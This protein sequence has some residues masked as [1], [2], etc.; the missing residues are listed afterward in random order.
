MARHIQGSQSTLINS[1]S[2]IRMYRTLSFL[3]QLLPSS[4]ILYGCCASAM[5][6]SST[7]C[8]ESSGNEREVSMKRRRDPETIQMTNCRIGIRTNRSNPAVARVLPGS[9]FQSKKEYIKS[10]LVSGSLSFQSGLPTS[11]RECN[12]V[13]YRSVVV[14]VIPMARVVR[15]LLVVRLQVAIVLVAPKMTVL[16]LLYTRL[17][18]LL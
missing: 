9:P 17:F 15:L 8:I 13:S 12:T 4:P 10:S 5:S 6:F 14:V 1:N 18:I 11:S 2:K 16:L 3:H 7:T